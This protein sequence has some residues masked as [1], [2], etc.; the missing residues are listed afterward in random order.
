MCHYYFFGC[1]TY[2]V[3]LSFKSDS[4][5][6]PYFSKN[7]SDDNVP[8]ISMTAPSRIRSYDNS[9][10][11][12][13]CICGNFKGSYRERSLPQTGILPSYFYAKTTLLI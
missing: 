1:C 2:I 11:T 7:V 5:F 4:L 13:F 9:I 10:F 3:N 8:S 6:S 12:P